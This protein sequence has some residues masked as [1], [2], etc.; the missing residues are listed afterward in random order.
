MFCGR[1]FIFLFQSFPLGDKSAVNLRGEFHTE[2]VTAFDSKGP[3]IASGSPDAMQVD[4]QTV[5]QERQMDESDGPSTQT[6][7]KSELDQKDIKTEESKAAQ[8]TSRG[9]DSQLKSAIV[10][11]PTD[12]EKQQQQQQQEEALKPDHLYSVFWSLQ[13]V[14]SNP[15]K[16][17]DGQEFDA[18]RSA[19]ELTIKKFKSMPKVPHLVV[20]GSKAGTKRRRH[21]EGEDFASTFN[22]KYLTSRDLFELEMSD[23]T[24]QRHILV[25]SLILLDFLL[26]LTPKAKKKISELKAQKAMVYNYTLSD[27]NATWAMNMKSTIAA[28]LQEGSDG[29]FYYRMVDNVLS[30]DKNWVQWKMESCPPIERD[31]IS[32]DDYKSARI[33]AKRACTNKRLKATPLGSIDLSFLSDMDNVNNLETLKRPERFTAPEPETLL[34]TVPNLDLDISEKNE[35]RGAFD[36]EQKKF[37]EEQR[38]FEAKQKKIE[39]EQKAFEDLQKKLSQDGRHHQTDPQKTKHRE[40]LGKQRAELKQQRQELK[41]ERQERKIKLDAEWAGLVT[42]RASRT[43]RSLRLASKSRIKVFDRTDEARSMEPVIKEDS[44]HDEQGQWDKQGSPVTE[45]K[46]STEINGRND[47]PTQ[48]IGHEDH[49]EIMNEAPREEEVSE[50]ERGHEPI[51]SIS[52]EESVGMG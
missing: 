33:G 5:G 36:K 37:D 10:S 11:V 47:A 20:E 35:E 7:G 46:T 43:W 45:V 40:E 29:K 26:S 18:F 32:T 15:P 14:F 27:E 2:N 51:P 12:P 49:D 41:R 6:D 22:P 38:A 25:Q 8:P 50:Q 52:V 48:A 39:Q 34:A 31:P 42:E 9:P 44:A 3:A 17:F 30:R 13:H 24:F 16:I 1:V 28:Y 4:G 19:L 21:E 23:Q